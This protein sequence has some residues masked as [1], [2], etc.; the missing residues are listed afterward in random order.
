MHP[1]TVE[2]LVRDHHATL[3]R[4][5]RQQ[6]LAAAAS[7]TRQAQARNHRWRFMPHVEEHGRLR[8][9]IVSLLRPSPA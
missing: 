8:R 2:E 9:A 1:Y 3:H 5:A 4:E 6:A 7:R